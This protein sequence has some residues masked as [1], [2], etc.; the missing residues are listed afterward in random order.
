MSDCMTRRASSSFLPLGVY[1][2]LGED[3][4]LTGSG[5]DWA[6][7]D[8]VP[9]FFEPGG[10]SFRVF[11]DGTDLSWTV[12]SKESD[13]KVRNAANA[14]SSST[15]CRGNGNGNGT[16]SATVAT[17]VNEILP[18]QDELVA[19][20]N[21]VGEKLYISMKDIEHYKMI[22]LYDFA[23]RSHP[24]T[25]I[26]KR[27]DRLEIEMIHLSPGHYFIRIEMEDSTQVVPIIKQ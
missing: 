26:D 14:N 2:P 9:T 13:Q 8:P 24:I 19:Y 11:F 21:P 7:S 18:A 12:S 5:I 15:K 17:D 23:G 27:S 10:G 22:V 16:K 25:S 3:N 4:L 20:P 6:N 1:I